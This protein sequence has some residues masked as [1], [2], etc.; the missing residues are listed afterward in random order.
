[1]LGHVFNLSQSVLSK[2]TANQSPNE[3][4]LNKRKDDYYR[5]LIGSFDTP[6]TPLNRPLRGHVNDQGSISIDKVCYFLFNQSASSK[7]IRADCSANYEK[8]VSPKRMI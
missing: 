5:I 7:M 2:I 6:K 3:V 8:R 1:M 4:R